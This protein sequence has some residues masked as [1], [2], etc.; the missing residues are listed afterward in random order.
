MIAT[1][2]IVEHFNISDF[3]ITGGP[4]PQDVADKIL[5]HH[6]IPLARVCQVSGLK[7]VISKRSGYR[8]KWYEI[9]KKRSGDSQHTFEGFGAVDITCEN[10]QEHKWDLIAHLNT[11][12]QYKRIALYDSKNFIHLDYK[13]TKRI[14]FDE[15]WEV[16]YELT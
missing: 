14:L 16:M 15:N 2:K 11:E 1:N 7:L 5:M 9:K 10:F 8:P 6:L 13:G 4:I 3:N 12:T